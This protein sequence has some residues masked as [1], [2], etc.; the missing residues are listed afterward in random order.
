MEL[1]HNLRWS[2]EIAS[3]VWKCGY[4]GP[5]VQARWWWR[6]R[7]WNLKLLL[8]HQMCPPFCAKRH[9]SLGSQLA[10]WL[11][12]KI[13]FMW[14]KHLCARAYGSLADDVFDMLSSIFTENSF[15][16]LNGNSGCP[17]TQLPG[18]HPSVVCNLAQFFGRASAFSLPHSSLLHSPEW[19]CFNLTL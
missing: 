11:C 7:L 16:N 8:S 4:R 18:A 10:T 19:L 9:V 17:R 13:L 1:S 5:S 15:K 6:R 12:G 3:T 14:M 2:S